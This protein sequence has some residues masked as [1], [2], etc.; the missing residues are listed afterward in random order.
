MTVRAK[1]WRKGL[2]KLR[3]LRT[4]GCT[5][6]RDLR[7]CTPERK[8]LQGV[9]ELR[10]LSQDGLR[11]MCESVLSFIR[12]IQIYEFNQIL[13]FPIGE[14][15]HVHVHPGTESVFVRALGSADG[16]SQVRIRKSLRCRQRKTARSR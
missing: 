16:A 14:S 11:S 10:G 3:K 12:L 4:G 7:G 13:T 6:A 5:P 2:R 15:T 9:R 1:G 8:G